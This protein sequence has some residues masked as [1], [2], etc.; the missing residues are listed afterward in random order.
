MDAA[1]ELLRA[2]AVL[3]Y[4]IDMKGRNCKECGSTL[5]GHEALMSFV[6]GF[7]NAPRCCS[8]LAAA[9]GRT[10]EEMRDHFF[11]Y[12]ASHRCHHSGWVWANRQE[13]FEPA[14][15][16]GCLW[17]NKGEIMESRRVN[18]SASDASKRQSHTSPDLEWDAGDMGCGDL[19]LHLRLRLQSMR[20]GQLLKLTARD[21]GAP[22]DLPAW[23]R[24]TGHTLLDSKHPVYWIKRKEN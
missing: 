11:G 5:C 16:P 21:P 10:R 6:A 3:R 15:L 18:Q 20:P 19:V 9:H 2:A 22:E 8:C 1:Q 4:L 13:D 14:A 12:V 23:C 7:K 17:P 24:M